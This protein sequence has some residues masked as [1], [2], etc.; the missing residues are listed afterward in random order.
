MQKLLLAALLAVF[1]WLGTAYAGSG[2]AGGVLAVANGMEITRGQWEALYATLP[3]AD[4]QLLKSSPQGVEKA[5]LEDMID[6]ELLRQLALEMGLPGKILTLDAALK[7]A[8]ALPDVERVLRQRELLMRAALMQP[9]EQ[10]VTPQSV[11]RHYDLHKEHYKSIGISSFAAGKL[12]FQ[13][14]LE[15]LAGSDTNAFLRAQAS[16]KYPARVGTGGN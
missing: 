8:E 13:A 12:F 4:L 6:V 14:W 16:V 15:K 2:T 7:A 10:L 5:L 9:S 3:P 1:G 11:E